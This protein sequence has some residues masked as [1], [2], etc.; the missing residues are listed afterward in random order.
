MSS[1]YLAENIRELVSEQKSRTAV[2]L[3]NYHIVFRTKKN[4]GLF[5]DKRTRYVL[6]TFLG[7]A[8]DK[9][10]TILAAAV[11]KNHVHLVISLTSTDTISDVLHILK[12]SSSRYIREEYPDL[13]EF[14]KSLWAAGYFI[15]SVGL[16][17]VKQVI[18]YVSVRT[19][20]TRKR[21]SGY[22]MVRRLKPTVNA[23]RLNLLRINA[24]VSGR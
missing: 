8:K 12:G 24:Q 18:H 7:I 14:D 6:T 19:N 21:E 2:Y 10:Y 15:E 5:N 22:M 3:L 16:K 1:I 11:V 23:E 17:D 9:G 20:I 13:K 4:T